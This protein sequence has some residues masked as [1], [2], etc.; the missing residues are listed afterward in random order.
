MKNFWKNLAEKWPILAL[1][2][3]DG[4]T[5]SAYRQT[6][7]KIS[8]EVITF[9]E[10]YSADGLV[11]SK[12]LAGSVLPHQD[13]EKPLIIQ[14]FWKDPEMFARAAEIIEQYNIAGIDINMWCPAKKVVR[15]GHGSCLIINRDTAFEIVETLNKRSKLPISVKTRLGFNGSE[16]LID[17][18]K[19]LE[20]AGAA[21]LTVH[22]RTASQWYTWHADFTQIY[23]L[24][25]HI[26]IPVICNGDI[27]NYEDGM[28]KLDNLNGFMIG[29]GSFGNPW[30]FLKDWD[31]IEK[32]GNKRPGSFING[33]YQPTL[34]EI[35]EM[36][37]FHAK[38]L[39]TCKWERKG[40]LDIRKHLV[41]YLKWF[42][43]V[44]AYR[45]RL[46]TIES[47]EILLGIIAE[48]K[49][50]FREHLSLLP[51]QI[52]NLDEFK[53]YGGVD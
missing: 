50:E 4:Y 47:I 45:K 39:V 36:M 34:G 42:P 6:V 3:M 11:H 26:N 9:S 33:Q 40:T 22:G 2:P 19:W 53:G 30:C 16:S 37:E 31:L 35:L 20:S 13:I 15:S 46:V 29:R 44:W 17:F 38:A 52:N 14:I 18:A 51:L 5:D 28:R 43:W 10:F 23:E 8:P 27:M 32:N 41:Q 48:I 25:K 1:A 7:K 12:F 21:S 24:K 49:N